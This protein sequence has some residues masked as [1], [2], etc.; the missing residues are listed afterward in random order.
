MEEDKGVTPP[1]ISQ[2]EKREIRKKNFFEKRKNNFPATGPRKFKD[3]IRPAH[4]AIFQNYKDQGFRSLGKAI[5]KTGVYSEN[6]EKRVNIITKTKSWQLLMAEYMPEE[7]LAKRHAEL[8][9]KRSYR[10]VE[11]PDGTTEDVDDGPET[12]AV[13][14]GLELAYRLRGSFQKEEAPPPS[15]VMYNLFYK[16]EVREQMRVFEDGLKLSLYNE[17]NK[18][19]LADL[20]AEQEN[21]DNI[22]AGGGVSPSESPTEPTAGTSTG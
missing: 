10:K 22:A 1:S 14:K 9:D 13:T 3:S 5:R 8:L 11:N 18:R 19:N 20:E 15:T 7:H 4:R 16:P 6:I 17:I 21:Q 2:L 12:A